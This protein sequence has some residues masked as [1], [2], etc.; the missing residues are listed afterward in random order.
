MDNDLERLRHLLLGQDYA[1]L[2]KLKQEY[3]SSD[4]FAEAVSKVLAE[5]MARRNASDDKVAQVLAPIIDGAIANSIDQ[6]PR[7]LAESLYPIMGPAIRKSISETLQQMLENFNQLLEQSLSPKSLGWRFDAWRT[8]RSYSELVLFNTLE[9]NVEQVFMIHRESSLLLQHVYSDLA[10]RKDPDMVSSMFSAIQDFIQDS[11][12]T[13]EGDVLDTLKLG[14]LS[15]VIQS[16][17]GAVL[18]AVVRGIVPEHL[19]GRLQEAS[20]T[21]HQLKRSD[22]RDYAGDPDVFIDIEP[23]LRS[24]LESK[25]KEEDSG[26]RRFP[27]LAV[28]AIAII[29]AVVGYFSYQDLQRREARAEIVS[30]VDNLPGVVVLEAEQVESQHVITALVDPLADDFSTLLT[31]ALP[32]LADSQ[33]VAYTFLSGEDELVKRRVQRRV[34]APDGVSYDVSEGVLTLSGRATVQWYEPIAG[35][36]SGVTGVA[37][38]NVEALDLHDPVAD[39]AMRLSKTIDSIEFAF[40]KQESGLNSEDPSLQ[41]LATAML[42]LLNINRQDDQKGADRFDVVGYTDEGGTRRVNYRISQERADNLVAALTQLGV[43]K[44][45]MRA[46]SSFDYHED[47]FAPSRAARIYIVKE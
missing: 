8:G 1:E 41:R 46:I 9:Y 12:S 26:G 15:V 13:E 16:G 45:R 35:L 20:E 32:E 43:P 4:E 34:P 6:D 47:R 10:E 37:S 2:L 11:F 30:A 38:V 44:D 14:E 27:L 25:Q 24:V 33:V 5:A 31:P 3:R 28:A 42:G 19:R 23:N 17:P 39:A 40:E 22:L 29:L 36:L 21:V 7:K 18:A